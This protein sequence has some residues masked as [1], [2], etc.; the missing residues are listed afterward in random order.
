L[1][2]LCGGGPR[3]VPRQISQFFYSDGNSLHDATNSGSFFDELNSIRYNWGGSFAER[4][5]D[6]LSYTNFISACCPN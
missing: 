4:I 3:I 1:A 2:F 6:E 5:G